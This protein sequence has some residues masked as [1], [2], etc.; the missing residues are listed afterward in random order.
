M[1][2]PGHLASGVAALRCAAPVLVLLAGWQLVALALGSDIVPGVGEVAALLL[3]HALSDPI[4]RSQGGGEHGFLPHVLITTARVAAGVGAGAMVG[5]ATAAALFQWPRWRQSVEPLIE[6]LRV[7][8]PLILIPFVLILMGPTEVAQIAVCALYSALSMLVHTLNALRNVPAAYWIIARMQ[9][10]SRWQMLWTMAW[11]AALPEL[12]GGIRISLALALGIVI[13]CEYLGAPD[14]I[15]RV[16]KFALSFARID[17]LLVG[18]VWAALI[19]LLFD[20][21]VSHA[22]RRRTLWAEMRG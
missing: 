16:L 13:V 17:M 19:G 14:G 3:T 21:A 8:P 10:A 20:R 2:G 9:G 6:T 7:I 22:I 1:Q 4:I 15:G 18:L 12:L 11:P 5:A